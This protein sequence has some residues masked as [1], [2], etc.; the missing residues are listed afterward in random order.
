LP[1]I[2]IRT[3]LPLSLFIRSKLLTNQ[4]EQDVPANNN[5]EKGLISRSDKQSRID[6]SLLPEALAPVRVT[7]P[8]ASGSTMGATHPENSLAGPT[9]EGD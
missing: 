6:T 3:I 8:A 5:P 4:E 2:S 7:L 1:L 9:R